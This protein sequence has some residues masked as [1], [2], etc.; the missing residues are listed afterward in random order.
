MLSY[1]LNMKQKL[2]HIARQFDWRE[3]IPQSVICLRQGYSWRLFYADL[4]AGIGMGVLAL[5]LNMA[6]AIACGLPPEVGLYTAIVAGFLNGLLGGSTVLIGGPTG[7]FVVIVYSILEKHGYEGLA[8]ATLMA[9]VFL[10]LMGLARFGVMLKFV[11]YPVITGFTSG[12]AVVLI[13]L[14]TRDL[15]GLQIDEQVSARFLDT[16]KTNFQYLHTFNPYAIVTAIASLG[17]ILAVRRI[18]PRAPAYLVA[19]VLVAG[20]VW[21]LQVPVETIGSR[22]TDLPNRLPSPALPDIS[23]SKAITLMPEAVTIA[24]LAALESLLCALVADGM[25]GT[26]HKSDC[27]LVA[28]GFSNIGSV[29]FHGIPA[30]GA[31]ART[32]ANIRMGAKTPVAAMIHAV[33]LLL[34]MVL[35]APYAK[36]IPM[37]T[38]GAIMLVVAWQMSEFGRIRE[39]MRAPKGD[40]LVLLIS[41]SLTVLV[42]LTI[43]VQVGILLSTLLFIKHMRDRMTLSVYSSVLQEKD[44]NNPVLLDPDAVF[45]RDIPDEIAVFE[46]HGPLFFGVSDILHEAIKRLELHPY[47]FFILRLRHVPLIDATGL[48]AILELHDSCRRRGMTLLLSGVSN[49]LKQTFRQSGLEETIDGAN[50]FPHFDAALKYAKS[51]LATQN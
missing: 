25:A 5:P 28:Q 15:L 50:I 37:A 1:S 10:I 36:L 17:L 14:Q 47:R 9:G 46:V 2:L 16:W 6:F 30:T 43:A 22:F 38:L 23:V 51:E 44:E 26:R 21:A 48:Q 35:F 4:M 29:L 24:M 33:V 20:A 45:K 34:L 8:I 13:S 49:Y 11:S 12:I 27:E 42:D 18:A 39:L 3:Y 40:V 31:I 19:V 32:A 41:F 7:A